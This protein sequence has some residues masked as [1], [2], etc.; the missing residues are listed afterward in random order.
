MKKSTV[1]PLAIIPKRPMRNPSIEIKFKDLCK[2]IKDFIT[3]NETKNIDKK[4]E[5]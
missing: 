2:I 1:K 3:K 4:K 5:I